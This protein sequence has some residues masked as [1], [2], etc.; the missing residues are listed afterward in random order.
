MYFQ[1][2]QPHCSQPEQH[3]IALY[4]IFVNQSI[5]YCDLRPVGDCSIK[6]LLIYF[7]VYQLNFIMICR[8]MLF[9]MPGKIFIVFISWFMRGCTENLCATASRQQL[10]LFSTI[11]TH[12]IKIKWVAKH[13]T[14]RRHE[15]IS[16][17]NSFSGE[18]AHTSCWHCKPFSRTRD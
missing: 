16:V 11:N 13:I 14:L 5:S 12:A 8:R 18:S 2:V 9:L 3:H 1:Q 4:S 7:S 10:S 17:L 15:S 6:Y